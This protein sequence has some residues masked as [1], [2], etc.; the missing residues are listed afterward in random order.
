MSGTNLIWL[1][2]RLVA[3]REAHVQFGDYRGHAVVGTLASDSAAYGGCHAVV[4]PEEQGRAAQAH[5][6]AWQATGRE[7]LPLSVHGALYSS[8]ARQSVIVAAATYHVPG[9][10]RADAAQRCAALRHADT[11]RQVAVDT[12]ADDGHEPAHPGR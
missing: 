6:A 10:V 12:E 3:W 1:E 5:L 11:I 8:G 7:D 9:A 4:F 2:G